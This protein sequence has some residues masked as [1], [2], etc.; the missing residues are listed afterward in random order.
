VQ[1]RLRTRAWEP[2]RAPLPSDP[3]LAGSDG[4]YIFAASSF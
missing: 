3:P 2:F 4:V 1:R